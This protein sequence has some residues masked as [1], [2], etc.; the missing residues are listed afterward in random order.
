LAPISQ[1]HSLAGICAEH[2]SPL[3]LTYYPP[4]KGVVLSYSNAQLSKHPD[5]EEEVEE[6][7]EEGEENMLDLLLH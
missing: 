3:I 1:L 6:E 4:F 7:E 2:L 5:L